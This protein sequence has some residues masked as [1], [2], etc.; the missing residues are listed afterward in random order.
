[1]N[2]FFFLILWLLTSRIF[3]YVYL[4]KVPVVVFTRL[5]QSI[6]VT[7]HANLIIKGCYELMCQVLP[8][9]VESC[10]VPR[11]LTITAVGPLQPVICLTYVVLLCGTT[12]QFLI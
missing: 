1:M 12:S 5:C 7:K 2:Y 4:L 3:F 9:G 6:G 10:T 11:C 8:P